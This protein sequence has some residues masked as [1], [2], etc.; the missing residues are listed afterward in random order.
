[1]EPGLE[2]T[3][4]NIATLSPGPDLVAQPVGNTVASLVETLLFSQMGRCAALLGSR[5]LHTSDA[6]K[7]MGAQ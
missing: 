3:W 1:M 4:P 7:P 5:W 2:R 6:E